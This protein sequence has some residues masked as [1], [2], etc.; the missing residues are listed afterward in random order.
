MSP[1][2]SR[3]RERIDRLRDWL[4][5]VFL[6]VLGFGQS[7]LAVTVTTNAPGHIVTIRSGVDV[8]G[9]VKKFNLKPSHIYRHALNG[10]AAPMDSAVI[11]KLKQDGRIL[12][13][14]AD[15]HIVPCGKTI[16]AGILRMGITNFPV[17]HI[18]GQ[19]NR[20]NVDV[21]VLDTG[22]Q[23]NHPDLNVGQAVGFAD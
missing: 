17:A 6:A 16:P 11:E 15:G 3:N 12:A 18:N 8:D 23:T 19:D 20:I 14:E 5:I 2:R 13:V 10:F 4:L 9:L 7:S 22:I 1:S 21:A